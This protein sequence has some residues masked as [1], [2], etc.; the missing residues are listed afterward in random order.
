MRYY[1]YILIYCLLALCYFPSSMAQESPSTSA[2]ASIRLQLERPSGKRNIRMACLRLHSSERLTISFDIL[3][4][5][6]QTLRYQIRHCDADGQVST[7]SEGECL[8]GISEQDLSAPSPSLGTKIPYLHYELSLPNESIDFK[9]SGRYLLSIYGT[10]SEQALCSLPLFV[11]EGQTGLSLQ[12]EDPFFADTDRQHQSLVLRLDADGSPSLKQGDMVKVYTYQN[13]SA[14]LPPCLLLNPSSLN[15]HEWI[16]ERRQASIFWAGND[17]RYV[18][19]D[20]YHAH[21]DLSGLTLR[22][23]IVLNPVNLAT[24]PLPLHE[25]SLSSGNDKTTRPE[26]QLAEDE[27]QAEYQ[28][29]RFTLLS[30]QEL[31]GNIYL[32]GSDFDHLPLERKRLIYSPALKAYQLTLPLKEG[33]QEYR[34]IF[35]PQEPTTYAEHT[36]IDGSF[37]ETPNSYTSLVFYRPFGGRYDRLLTM[38]ELS[39][40]N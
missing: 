29:I 9:L 28:F 17:Y 3:G 7:L 13:Q 12:R 23:T 39:P 14:L 34:Y 27:T 19:H 25:I 38:Q 18:E 6:E 5:E 15:A 36:P 40:R 10:D 32:E 20:R 35:I 26:H 4:K 1:N 24:Q 22:D 30:P 37:F 31:E 11:Y 21:D 2:V 16:Y 33:R 8:S